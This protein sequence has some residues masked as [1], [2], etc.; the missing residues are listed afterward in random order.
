VWILNADTGEIIRK[1]PGAP[2]PF[3]SSAF[4]PNG[5]YIASGGN[6]GKL[7]VWSAADGRLLQTVTVSDRTDVS[8][9]GIAFSRDSRTLA[10]GGEDYT[11]S[12]WDPETGAPLGRYGA[13]GGWIGKLSFA[14]NGDL[15]VSGTYFRADIW[16]RKGGPSATMHL[17]M[18]GTSVIQAV[19]S[20]DGRH[21]ATTGADGSAAIW[22]LDLD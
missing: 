15:A 7:R 8:L 11:V 2:K 4:S 16:D 17:E 13:F 18:A 1:L 12:L 19:F 20:P 6:D 5:A 14:P 21:M 22:R 3:W 10:V 9:R